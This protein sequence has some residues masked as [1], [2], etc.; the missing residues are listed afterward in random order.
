MGS[1]EEQGTPEI[2]ALQDTLRDMDEFQQQFNIFTQGKAHVP[3]TLIIKADQLFEHKDKL[4]KMKDMLWSCKRQEEKLTGPRPGRTSAEDRKK[5]E[6]SVSAR[7]NTVVQNSTDLIQACEKAESLMGN[8]QHEG[9]ADE[10]NQLYQTLEAAR[11]KIRAITVGQD[12]DEVQTPVAEQAMPLSLALLTPPYRTM[13]QHVGTTS[14]LRVRQR[15][16]GAA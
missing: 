5:M 16:L 8:S 14:S 2:A 3:E 6:E 7:I 1:F 10:V 11:K 13:E 9:V 12:V 15:K 4:S